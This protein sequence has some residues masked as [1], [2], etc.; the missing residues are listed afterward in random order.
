MMSDDKEDYE[1]NMESIPVA[2]M[3]REY[4]HQFENLSR[5]V[6]DDELR[7]DQGSYIMSHLIVR[8]LLSIMDMYENMIGAMRPP[9][10]EDDLLQ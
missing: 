10:D 7:A 3:V 2:S 8:M 4:T 5:R 9:P 1:L 6:Q